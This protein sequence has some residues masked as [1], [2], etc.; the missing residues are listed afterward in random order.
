[1]TTYATNYYKV[2][3]ADRARSDASVM[4]VTYLLGGVSTE[5]NLEITTAVDSDS[6]DATYR[7]DVSA[8]I[9]DGGN[10]TI[11]EGAQITRAAVRTD[12]GEEMVV[13]E[14]DTALVVSSAPVTITL[15]LRF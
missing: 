9:N 6:G 8:A 11:T 10:N 15:S 4:R 14:Y 1:M 3:L 2:T 5:Q 7:T 12:S 13:R